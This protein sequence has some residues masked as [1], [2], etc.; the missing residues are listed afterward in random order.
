MSPFPTPTDIQSARE[1]EGGRQAPRSSMFG[2]GSPS[3]T[4]AALVVGDELLSGK[5]REANIVVLARA[6][7]ELG[8]LMRRVVVV[9]DD[10]DAIAEEVRLLSSTH[11]WL[12]TSGGIGPTHDDLTIEGVA[13]AFRGAGRHFPRPRGPTA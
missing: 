9:M 3:P 8:V 4:A 5:V 11:D 12:F 6:L 7:R 2:H 13:R 1:P 10:V